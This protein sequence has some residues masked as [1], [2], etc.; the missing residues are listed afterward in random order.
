M[1]IGAEVVAGILVAVA[2]A[3]CCRTSVNIV[4]STGYGLRAGHCHASA[5]IRMAPNLLLILIKEFLAFLS[6]R[7]IHDNLLLLPDAVL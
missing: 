7:L 6:C 3:T 1:I 4:K 2:C 5:T